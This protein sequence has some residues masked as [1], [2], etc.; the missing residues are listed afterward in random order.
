MGKRATLKDI[1]AAAHVTTATVSYVIN[2]TP[3]QKIAP[4]TRERILA[5][6]RE[7]NYVPS[8]AARTLRSKRS[9][10]VGVVARKN[11]AVPRFSQTIRGIQSVLEDRDISLLLCANRLRRDGMSDYIGAFYEGRV[12]GV[13]FLG[14]DNIGPGKESVDQIRRGKIPFVSYDCLEESDLY[15]TVDLDYRGGAQRVVAK[16]LERSPRRLLYLQPQTGT[17]QESQRLAGVAEALEGAPGVELI[18]A[19]MPVTLQNLEVWDLRYSVGTTEEGEALTGRFLE[20]LREACEPLS[21]G[22]AVVA[23]WSGWVDLVQRVTSKRLV[24][25]ELANNGESHF[26]PDHYMRLPNYEVGA[27]CARELLSLM[28][29]NPPSSRVIRLTEVSHA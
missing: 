25:A 10:A 28:E 23:S 26:H 20:A 19:D 14:R 4:A 12:D 21:D 27:V 8:S 6:A 13:I 2:R 29:G 11:L 5:I 18:V 1:A 22:D 24:T 16:A 17:A 3:G 7:L 15:S 9:G